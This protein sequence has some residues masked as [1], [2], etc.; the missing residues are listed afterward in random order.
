MSAKL[1]P[2]QRSKKEDD[3]SAVAIVDALF[4]HATY[5][6]EAN[7]FKYTDEACIRD[8]SRT[9][10]GI[11]GRTCLEVDSKTTLTFHLQDGQRPLSV[12]SRV[13]WARGESFGVEFLRLSVDSYERMQQYV[14]QMLKDAGH[15][16]VE[17]P[18]F[19]K[20]RHKPNLQLT[21]VLLLFFGSLWGCATVSAPVSAPSAPF[22]IPTSE[23]RATLALRATELDAVAA[24]CAADNSCDE[25]MH[26]SRALISLFENREAARASFEQVI[27]RHPSSPLAATSA[28][29]LQL[30]QDERISSTPND[31]QRQILIDLSAQWVREWMERRLAVAAG[32]SRN[33]APGKPV[34]TKVLQKQLDERK[35]RINELR[36]QL[37]T[38][39]LIDQDQ[40]SRY[41]RVRPPASLKPESENQR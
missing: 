7:G 11:R 6:F 16:R 8:L 23:E 2:R 25:E 29:W 12:A 20:E 28:L 19:A 37:D 15:D 33:G 10:C 38:L 32:T 13:I 9:G 36:S 34:A 17:V 1:Q 40:Q 22:F 41:R 5:T 35:R 3:A 26:F 27:T 30:L 4:W 14:Q 21:S 24:K 18:C 39:K 31:P